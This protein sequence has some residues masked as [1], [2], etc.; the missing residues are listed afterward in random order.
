[1]QFHASMSVGGDGD[2]AA[3]GLPSPVAHLEGLPSPVERL[4]GV[5]GLSGIVGRLEGIVAPSSA[6]ERLPVVERL[7]S[8]SAAWRAWRACRSSLAAPADRDRT[9]RAIACTHHPRGKLRRRPQDRRWRP[10]RAGRGEDE[11]L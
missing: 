7:P 6:L 2:R 3:F 8:S 1:M 11:R 10:F 4:E 5:E 9:T